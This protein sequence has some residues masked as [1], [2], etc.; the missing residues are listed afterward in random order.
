MKKFYLI[1]IVFIVFILE[2][3]M[4]V[5]G[6]QPNFSAALAYY[7]GLRYGANKGLFWGAAIGII[8]DSLAKNMIGPN[9]LGKAAVGFSAA[10][11]SGTVFRWTPFTGMIYMFLLSALD[12]IITSSS[13]AIFSNMPVS[14]SNAVLTILVSSVLNSF[15]GIFMK[16][17]DE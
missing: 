9:L 15:L 8:G 3:R 12:G 13:L 6:V 1:I 11:T 5:F 7:F 4:S 16:P 17:K 2:S 14:V 10:F